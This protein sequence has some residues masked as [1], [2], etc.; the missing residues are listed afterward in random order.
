[1]AR[2]SA[3]LF[4]IACP[5]CE[6]E[7]QIDPETHAVISHKEHK[8]PSSVGDLETA[9]SR[10]KGEAQRR[11]DAF[12]KSLAQQKDHQKVLD[13]KFDELLRQAKENP[14]EAPPKRDIDFD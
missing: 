14:D 12:Q 11:E 13:R 3:E 8:R 5:C 2:R 1:M 10:L 4:T 9:V 6:A 7:L